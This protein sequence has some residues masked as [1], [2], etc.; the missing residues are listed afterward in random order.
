MIIMTKIGGNLGKNM[1]AVKN[2]L[3][4][5]VTSLSPGA[6]D[7]QTSASPPSALRHSRLLVYPSPDFKLDEKED[8]FLK[9]LIYQYKL[10]PNLSLLDLLF[11]DLHFELTNLE[12]CMRP[13]DFKT[14][15]QALEECYGNLAEDSMKAAALLSYL[16]NVV[17]R[18]IISNNKLRKSVPGSTQHVI[19]VADTKL[20]TET[21]SE[22]LRLF[23]KFAEVF[24]TQPLFILHP[25]S[26]LG[27]YNKLVAD[28]NFV[29]QS[30]FHNNSRF[31]QAALGALSRT[32]QKISALSENL[33]STIKKIHVISDPLIDPEVI[34]GIHHELF[35]QTCRLDEETPHCLS[36]IF[37]TSFTEFKE[38][39]SESLKH[40][41]SQHTEEVEM[42]F[43]KGKP[44]TPGGREPLDPNDKLSRF[45]NEHY[46]EPYFYLTDPESE[47]LQELFNTVHLDSNMTLFDILGLAFYKRLENLRR[48]TRLFDAK[49][50]ECQGLISAYCVRFYVGLQR[51][52]SDRIRVLGPVNAYTR[53]F[54]LMAD[55]F[56]EWIDSAL[57]GIQ[58]VVKATKADG[59]KP[60][61]SQLTTLEA[62]KTKV[63]EQISQTIIP[64][65]NLYEKLLQCKGHYHLL[66]RSVFTYQGHE[67]LDHRHKDGRADI[68]SYF[69]W[70]RKAFHTGKEYQYFGR[71]FN[72]DA[73][74]KKK[75]PFSERPREKEMVA[76]GA[77]M[78]T[79][80]YSTELTY[81]NSNLELEEAVH[82]G[83]DHKTWLA[84]HG[85]KAVSERK[86]EE[87]VEQIFLN[88]S[89]TE[90]IGSFL[91]DLLR[92][93]EHRV[94]LKGTLT[95]ERCYYRLV[96]NMHKYMKK[97]ET[98]IQTGLL[99]HSITLNFN[100]ILERIEAL[101]SENNAIFEFSV[102]DQ[103]ILE[104]L[105]PL[106]PFLTALLE[107]S[108]ADLTALK[109]DLI[110]D[111]K[112]Q[113]S[114]YSF[115]QLQLVDVRATK[116]ALFQEG[117]QVVRP[118]W[119]L[120][121]MLAVLQ[122][123]HYSEEAATIPHQLADIMELDE[124]QEILHKLLEDKTPAPAKEVAIEVVIVEPIPLP[125]KVLAAVKKVET[126]AVSSVTRLKKAG[127]PKKQQPKQRTP[128][129]IIRA[130]QDE[131]ESEP[132]PELQ[133]VAH[134]T[135]SRQILERL[136]EMGYTSVRQTGSH[137]ILSGPEGGTV[138]VPENDNLPRGTRNGILKQAQ[139]AKK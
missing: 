95:T 87:F 10:L 8:A 126:P 86:Q 75:L 112:K 39:W 130:P 81:Q 38:V 27:G 123:R 53:S 136:K 45:K 46:V 42:A 26:I 139:D 119:I 85:I 13:E 65:R 24:T 109:E 96:N 32:N 138:V 9:D 77:K 111:L 113:W 21:L 15:I 80:I 71:S 115:E 44:V 90:F 49:I 93:V 122:I 133:E 98:H 88:L 41:R 1:S 64:L 40:F 110:L 28:N 62:H 82:D 132:L 135:K 68:E 131:E 16:K 52:S 69:D 72:F 99:S 100:K 125:V 116:E 76:F 20:I 84:R 124:I 3:S 83:L 106:E 61:R 34:M 14:E 43:Q 73:V 55:K 50:C 51:T 23:Q 66:L 37:Y 11:F 30:I 92:L 107:E 67:I 89:L 101:F 5:A 48:T 19:A 22:R 91:S 129:E 36:R 2:L 103:N 47:L 56:I 97:K 137:H 60:S 29:L 74:M 59:R 127:V 7:I 63:L 70:I 102:T 17:L 35:L 54:C 117:L 57:N 33:M 12:G 105:R 118:L 128:V 4:K 79:G 6:V 120:T 104:L 94:Y 58:D 121:D 18:V 25:L 114:K 31:L 134:L 78:A 108:L